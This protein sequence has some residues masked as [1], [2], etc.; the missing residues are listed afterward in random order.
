VVHGLVVLA[1]GLVVTR[2]E[3]Y[4]S[5]VITTSSNGTI[6][7]QDIAAAVREGFAG[8]SVKIDDGR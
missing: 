5:E 7:G 6:M 4:F 8:A 3:S 1:Q 2:R